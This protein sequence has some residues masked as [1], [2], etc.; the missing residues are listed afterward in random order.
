[1]LKVE[2]GDLKSFGILV[3][4]LAKIQNMLQNTRSVVKE[5]PRFNAVGKGLPNAG[6]TGVYVLR[7][8]ALRLGLDEFYFDNYAMEIQF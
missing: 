1:M 4:T 7:A 2:K 8:L 5:L 3:S 6:K